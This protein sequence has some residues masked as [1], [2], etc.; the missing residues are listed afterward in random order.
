M[1]LGEPYPASAGAPSLEPAGCP[2]KLPASG[3][4]DPL[5]S[6][7]FGMAVIME[8]FPRGSI[9]PSSVAARATLAPRA[10]AKAPAVVATTDEAR[11]VSEP[12]I[13]DADPIKQCDLSTTC[14]NCGGQ[15]Q[16][17]H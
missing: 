15:M 8:R 3:P 1:A 12:T 7:S 2:R 14:P 6:E 4:S 9:P 5:T 13:S 10:V 16:P 11:S 17:E